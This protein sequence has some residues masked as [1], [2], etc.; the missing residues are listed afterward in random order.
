MTEEKTYPMVPQDLPSV[1]HHD[2]FYIK[3]WGG[4]WFVVSQ[5]YVQGPISGELKEKLE[6]IYNSKK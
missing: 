4:E 3:L 5:G 2:S 1:Q 6:M